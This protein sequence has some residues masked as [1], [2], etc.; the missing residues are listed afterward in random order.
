[1]QV[2]LDNAA[3]TR[4]SKP[5]IELMN[6]AMDEDY[7]NPSAKHL[8]GMEAEKYLKEAAAKIAKT[9]KV[10]EKELVF[11][12]G[13][14]ESNNMAL[15]GAAMARQRYGKHI[16]S[17]AI[18]HSA[19]HQVLV[20]LAD[21]GFEYSILK[22][23]EK[24]QIS[25]EELKSLL[26][27]DTILV[28]VMYVN[29]EIGA[30][31][32]I[33]AIADIVHGYNKDIYMHTDAI[34]AYGK[35]KIFPKKEGIDL[36]S[37]SAHKL[38]GPKGSGFLYIDERVNIKPIIYGGGQQRGLRSGT[39][40]IPGIAGLGEAAKEAYKDFDKEV[41]YIY[42]L[43]DYLIDEITKLNDEGIK[44]N[45]EKGVK[46]APHVLSISISGVRAEVLLHA[47]EER[48]IYIAS[49]SACS[50]NHP[51]LSGTL[52]G[53]GLKEEFL[54]STVRVS[55]SKYNNKEELDFFLAN[56]KELIPQL[57]RYK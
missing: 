32:D 12:S 27:A 54:S 48:G 46:F 51:G 4:V 38:H 34:Q 7:A 21:L 1:M 15:I 42:S 49:G 31:Q 39:L 33:K 14:T 35:F 16:I 23:D 20:H 24:G 6:K 56:L 9:M 53:I 10:S 50:S 30:V 45:C 18:E 55:F 40:N 47:M 41:E 13:G 19:V 29:N 3:S 17:T 57:R 26:R 8:K 28:S 44:L 37:V 36:L 11:T 22:V 25:L 43:R 52:K 5:V 2:Y